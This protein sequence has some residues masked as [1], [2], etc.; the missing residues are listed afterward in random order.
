L[1]NQKDCFVQKTQWFVEE[2]LHSS[3]ILCDLLHFTEITAGT[4]CPA[5]TSKHNRSRTMIEC[6]GKR[7]FE[8]MCDL[9]VERIQ[10]IRPVQSQNRDRIMHLELYRFV[11][12][13][14]R[15]QLTLKRA[16]PPFA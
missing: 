1:T 12:H 4:K 10:A 16:L 9:H 5:R 2:S 3:V 15:R 13:S 7:G 6:L 11:A 8:V 14:D